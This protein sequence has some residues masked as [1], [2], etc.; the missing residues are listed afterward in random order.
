[1]SARLGTEPVCPAQ[2]ASQTL[3][4]LGAAGLDPPVARIARGDETVLLTQFK[5][6]LRDERGGYTVWSLVWFIPFPDSLR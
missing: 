4:D 3:L 6:L 2:L 5:G 1:M